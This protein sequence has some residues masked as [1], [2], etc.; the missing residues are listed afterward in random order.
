MHI[1]FQQILSSMGP[2]ALAVVSILALFGLYTMAVFF[3]RLWTFMKVRRAS[4]SFAPVASRALQ[5]GDHA[6]LAKAGASDSS[7]YLGQMLA[8][9][10]KTYLDAVSDPSP[11]ISPVELARR[12]LQRQ[13]D[14]VS[15]KLRRGLS[16]MASVGSTGP[17]VGLLGTVLGIIEAFAGI[18]ESGSGGIGAVSAGIAEALVVT[19]FGLMVAI[20]AVLCF[21]FLTTRA[22][23]ILLAIDQA[24]GEFTDYLEAHHTRTMKST[25]SLSSTARM[26]DAA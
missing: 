21:N 26:S 17:F 12:E 5:K 4:A 24:R 25:S 15:Q 23:H 10:V 11:D 14:L 13:A 16:G 7:N 18:A 22:D 2:A 1:D 20:P 19:A 3:E 6:G 9:G 8:S